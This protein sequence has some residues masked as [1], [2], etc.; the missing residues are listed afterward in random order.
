MRF[1]DGAESIFEK[2][3]TDAYTSKVFRDTETR[4]ILKATKPHLEAIKNEI[5]LNPYLIW[6]AN[7]W[8][9]HLLC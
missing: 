4:Y 8:A 1:K 7:H 2:L 9:P 3:H 6:P 5:C